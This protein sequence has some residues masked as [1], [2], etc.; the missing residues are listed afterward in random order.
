MAS[1]Q[2]SEPHITPTAPTPGP[3][4]DPAA[5]KGSAVRKVAVVLVIAA[6]IGG[7]VWKIRSNAKTEATTTTRSNAALADRPQPVLVATVAQKTMPIYLTALG[8]V[9]PYYSVTIKSRVDGQLMTVNVR[10]GQAVRKGQLLAEID[11]RPY[12]AALAQAQGQLVKDQATAENAK[13]QAQ[14]YTALLEAGV[15][16][17]ESQQGQI[18]TAGQ[19]VGSL[20]ADNAAIQAAKVNLAYSKI[21][22]PIDGIVGLRQVDPGNIV[23]A[24]DATGLML[25]TQLQ[26]ISVIFTLP[27]D[28]LPEVLRL[29]RS[30]KKLVVDA[31]DRSETTH[32]G[33][34]IVLTADNQIDPTTGTDKV[35][36]IFN[37]KDGALF[38]NQFVNIRLI[39]Q[40]R[41]NA[42]VVP[43]SAVQTGSQ[44]SYVFVVKKGQPPA[45]SR[46]AAAGGRGAGRGQGGGAAQ[47]ASASTNA[48][49]AAAG[50]T[51]SPQTPGAPQGAGGGAGGARGAN[52]PPYYVVAQP[53]K[54]DVTE[55]TQ[56][57]LASGL[58]AG[59][60]VVVDGQEKLLDGSRV[61]PRAQDQIPGAGGRGAASGGQSGTSTAAFGPGTAGPSDSP[62]DPSKRG[63][64]TGHGVPDTSAPRRR[65]N[66]AGRDGTGNGPHSGGTP[67]TQ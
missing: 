27:E 38:P 50:E 29:V 23:H 56:V 25:V 53:V 10:E 51:T 8:T 30:G 24:S 48:N 52:G 63:I 16:S 61:T 5:R 11:P 1:T 4:Q 47:G 62:T 26:P 6:V 57:I 45:G 21:T 31:Y 15:V 41:Q 17:K 42:I 65:D 32:L 14:R 9:T 19:A 39:L 55:G 49:S 66:G 64:E 2:L 22:S 67:P 7:A 54:V 36:S 13:A 12:E 37:N 58:N 59:D 20:E 46:G 44:G 60:Q 28:Q 3:P 34:G 43:A 18:A 40:Q 35:K 33:Q